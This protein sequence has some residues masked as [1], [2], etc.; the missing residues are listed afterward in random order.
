MIG[1]DNY[2]Y[3][4]LKQAATGRLSDRKTDQRM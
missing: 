2:P 1:S 3:I 4:M